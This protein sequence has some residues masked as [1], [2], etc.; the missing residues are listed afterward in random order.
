VIAVAKQP[1]AMTL[2]L[3]GQAVAVSVHRVD[4]HET[5]DCIKWE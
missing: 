2:D 4:L 3:V 1:Q 5:N